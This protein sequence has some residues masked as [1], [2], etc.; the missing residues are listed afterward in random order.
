[1]FIL[2][3]SIA[4]SACAQ[5]HFGTNK[6]VSGEVL[7]FRAAPNSSAKNEAASV[8]V[9]IPYVSG[10]FVLPRG[11]TNLSRPC[12]LVIVSVPSGGAAIRS[13]AAYTNVA[14][15]EGWAVFAADGPKVTVEQDSIQYGWG[16]LSSALEQFTATWPQVKRWPVACAGFSGGAKRSGAVAAALAAANWRVIGIFMGG[17]NEDIATL[18]LRLY[19]PP[20]ALKGVTIFLSNGNQDPIA[21]GELGSKVHA[22]LTS[23]GF[24]M[25]RRE[26]YDGAHRLHAEHVRQ[27]LQWFANIG[28]VQSAK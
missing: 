13:I 9:A 16:M 10:A 2:A 22:S 5:L 17:A 18:G 14:L 1:V 15:S 4:A 12:P 27:A 21:N 24:T 23:S 20:P 6:I 19:H 28:R 25:V 26:T 3:F 7:E 11:F 8:G